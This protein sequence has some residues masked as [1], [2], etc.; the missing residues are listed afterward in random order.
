VVTENTRALGFYDRLGFSRL[1]DEPGP[2]VYL[3]RA[4]LAGK[5]NARDGRLPSRAWE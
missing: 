5:Q 4:L 1:V 3:G 2:V